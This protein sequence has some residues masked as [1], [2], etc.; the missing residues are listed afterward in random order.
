M[1]PA[2]GTVINKSKNSLLRA[3]KDCRDKY[4]AP[5]GSE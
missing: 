2:V 3:Q 4:M 5:F 1:S